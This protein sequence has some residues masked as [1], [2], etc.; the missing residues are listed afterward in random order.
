MRDEGC[1]QEIISRGAHHG[2]AG[3]AG[4]R[5][6]RQVEGQ[7]APPLL[8]QGLASLT[9]H[10]SHLTPL[11]IT[12][13]TPG[14]DWIDDLTDSQCMEVFWLYVDPP[15]EFLERHR[16]ELLGAAMRWALKQIARSEPG[17]Q[18]SERA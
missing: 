7:R 6:V 18:A 13:T 2:D 15:E 14:T 1:G 11:S 10:P 4:R 3:V 12:P 16:P 17:A 5:A 9:P 8:S